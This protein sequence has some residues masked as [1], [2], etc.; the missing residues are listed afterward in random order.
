M[1]TLSKGQPDADR[2]ID[3]GAVVRLATNAGFEHL[4]R[5]AR[6]AKGEA[7]TRQDEEY[8]AYA[9]LQTMAAN[10]GDLRCAIKA[11]CMLPSADEGDDDATIDT[12]LVSETSSAALALVAASISDHYEKVRRDAGMKGRLQVYQVA[13]ADAR[14]GGSVMTS[15]HRPPLQVWP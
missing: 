14:L 2:S 1:A 12:V 8:F 10:L 13:E 15:L 3:L 4:A 6:R 9:W 11:V 7:M 5:M